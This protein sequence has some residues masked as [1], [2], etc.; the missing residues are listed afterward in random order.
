[1]T[2]CER[3]RVEGV[4]RDV[5]RTQPGGRER[6][7]ELVEQVAVGGHHD[8]LDAGD[9]REPAD[10][11][12]DPLRTVGSPPVSRILRTPSR[13]NTPTRRSSS[14]NVSRA[15][16]GSKCKVARHTLRHAVVQR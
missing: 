16:R 8:L 14:S 7:G 1:M 9:A 12:D 3:V 10:Q 4:E 15:E 13:A 5:D 11:L 6:R 2:A